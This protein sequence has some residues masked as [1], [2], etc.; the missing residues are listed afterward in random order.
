MPHRACIAALLVALSLADIGTAAPSANPAS[1]KSAGCFAVGGGYLRARMRGALDLDLNWG[2]AEMLCEGGPRPPGKDNTRNGVRV[3]IAGPAQADGH[4][5]RL[6]FGIAGVGEGGGGQSLRTNVTIL[7]E[8]E[9]R[10]YATQGDDKCTIDSLTQERVEV[11]GPGRAVY[12]V[13]A[14]GFCLGPATS[15]AG[16]ERVILTSFDFAGRVEFSDDDRRVNDKTP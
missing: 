5:L 1:D 9:Q 3:S 2:N 16:T 6:V 15:L 14:R 12:R 10:I 8:G 7:F 11:L 13:N 4:R